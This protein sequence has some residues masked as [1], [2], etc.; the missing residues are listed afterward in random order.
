VT[1]ISL[2]AVYMQLQEEVLKT[3]FL[4]TLKNAVRDISRDTRFTVFV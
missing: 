2:S 1:D 4:K 3:I